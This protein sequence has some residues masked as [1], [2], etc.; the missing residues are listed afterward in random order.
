MQVLKERGLLL[1]A[2]LSY[3]I[4]LGHSFAIS[5]FLKSAHRLFSKFL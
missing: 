4:W 5:A 3:F 1:V 2:T